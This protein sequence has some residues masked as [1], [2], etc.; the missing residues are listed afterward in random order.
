MC[1]DLMFR[2]WTPVSAGQTDAAVERLCALELPAVSWEDV[3]SGKARVE[4]YV[5][6]EEEAQAQARIMERA[7][8]ELLGRGIEV[9]VESLAREDW[10]D[11]WKRFFHVARVSPRIVVKPSWEPF[12]PK[13]GDCVVEVEPGMSFG[14]GLHG[15]TRACLAFLDELAAEN[16]GRS[17][18]DMGCG[19]GIL[20]IAAAKLGFSPIA[21]FD[22]DAVAVRISAENAR[23]NG[24]AGSLAISRHDLAEGAPGVTGDV[25]IANILAHILCEYADAVVGGLSAH[26]GAVLLLSGILEAQYADVVAA[27]ASRGL[28]EERSVVIDGWRTGWFVRA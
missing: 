6:A 15:T 26:A 16:A 7:L 27:F 18:V 23:S 28:R 10:T 5:E 3:D 21:A 12:E 11:V 13:A 20:S 22:H 14:T 2:V 9:R 4:C 8:G 25:V 24:V 1:D 19:S 17:V